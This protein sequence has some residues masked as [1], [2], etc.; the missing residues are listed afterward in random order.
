M[1]GVPK[2]EMVPADNLLLNI[3]AIKEEEV[4][5]YIE[6]AYQ[7]TEQ[8]LKAALEVAAPGKKEWELEAAARSHMVLAGA[9]GTPYPAWVC[10]GPNTRLSLCRSTSRAINTNELVQLT[11]GAKYMGYCGNMC[12]PFSIGKMPDKARDMAKVALESIDYVLDTVKPGVNSSDVFKGYHGILSKYGYQD[13]T[14]Y[15]PAHGTGSSEV[16]G[17]WLSEAS[18]FIIQ[19]NMLFNIDI[20][21]SDNHNGLRFEDGILVTQT[22]VKELTSFRREVIEL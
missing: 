9:E 17:L 1:E 13:Y 12:R 21:L 19:P 16:E 10:S 2:A 5:P 15:G 18:D 8:S 14:L 20:W 6:K 11:I 7:I 4:I 3:Q 22:G